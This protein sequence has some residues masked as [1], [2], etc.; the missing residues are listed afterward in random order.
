MTISL[1]EYQRRHG[2]IRK[3]ELDLDHEERRLADIQKQ[4]KEEFGVASVMEAKQLLQSLEEQLH[5]E[6]DRFHNNL[7]AFDQEYHEF[8]SNESS[9]I[10]RPSRRASRRGRT[11]KG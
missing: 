7:A 9:E 6:E 1:N 2:K 3:L 8:L 5:T 11:G 4:L 10:G